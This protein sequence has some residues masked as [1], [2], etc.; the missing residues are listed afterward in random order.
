[1][2]YVQSILRWLLYILPAAVGAR[3]AYCLCLMATDREQEAI[4]RRRIRNALIFLVIAESVDGLL[5]ILVGY[6][7]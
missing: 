7:A 3:C 5:H 4:Y 6:Y 1:M 2:D